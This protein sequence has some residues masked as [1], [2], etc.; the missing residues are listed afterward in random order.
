[1]PMKHFPIL[2]SVV[3]A[4]G[5]RWGH[6]QERQS[7]RSKVPICPQQNGSH[8]SETACKSDRLQL[9]PLNMAEN[10]MVKVRGYYNR[11]GLQQQ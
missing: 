4:Q 9:D 6:T 5:T 1:M 10:E 2:H 7:C 3:L 8:D 11:R